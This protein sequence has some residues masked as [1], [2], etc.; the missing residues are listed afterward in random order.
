MKEQLFITRGKPLGLHNY[1][2]EHVAYIK[3]EKSQ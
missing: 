3:V 1:V 2:F